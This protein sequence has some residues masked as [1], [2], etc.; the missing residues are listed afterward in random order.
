MTKDRNHRVRQ[1]KLAA[2]R[3]RNEQARKQNEERLKLFTAEVGLARLKY[4][5]DLGTVTGTSE[6]VVF[7]RFDELLTFLGRFVPEDYMPPQP[8]ELTEEELAEAG[9]PPLG[10]TFNNSQDAQDASERY[11]AALDKK[12]ERVA[13]EKAQEADRVDEAVL[14]E[15]QAR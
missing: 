1:E 12:R 2:A 9:L 6:R 8:I 15:E 5:L 10:T 14:E 13:L 11:Q 7:V 4:G 3:L